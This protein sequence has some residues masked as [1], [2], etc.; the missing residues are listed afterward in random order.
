MG[1]LAFT[2]TKIFQFREFFIHKFFLIFK[3]FSVS[4]IKQVH[5]FKD[6][7]IDQSEH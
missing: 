7:S 5:I 3:H 4:R 6:K 2:T 1:P